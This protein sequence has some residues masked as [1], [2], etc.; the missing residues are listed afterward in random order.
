MFQEMYSCYSFKDK[1]GGD[2]RQSWDH[3]AKTADGPTSTSI[4]MDWWTTP[5]NYATCRGK[6]NEGKTKKAFAKE[7]A[8]KMAEETTSHHCTAAQVQFKIDS[9][10]T[11]WRAAHECAQATGAGL[12]ERDL[13]ADTTTLDDY[14]G[15][16]IYQTSGYK[17]GWK[18]G[19]ILQEDKDQEQAIDDNLPEQIVLLDDDFGATTSQK[20]MSAVD[21]FSVDS[22]L[23]NLQQ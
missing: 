7:L 13:Q 11:Q 21:V 15:Q 8:D 23:A 3:D 10:A 16:S 9:T 18:L 17:L 19:Q 12:N 2:T 6:D 4:L 20:H 14:E 22:P 1:N 5:G